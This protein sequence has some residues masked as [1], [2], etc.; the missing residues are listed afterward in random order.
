MKA[1]K[2]TLLLIASVITLTTSATVPVGY[3]NSID[4]KRGQELKTAVHQ[5]LK[6]HTVMTYSSL[7]YHFQSTDCRFENPTQVWDMYSTI[8]LLPW[9]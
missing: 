9:L 8:T 5:L 1:L 4:G 7:W 6:N 2:N 3:Y